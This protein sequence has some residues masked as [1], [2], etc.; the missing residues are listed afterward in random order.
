MK[1]FF[2]DKEIQQLHLWKAFQIS[3][4]TLVTILPFQN[5]S[6]SGLVSESVS[7]FEAENQILSICKFNGTVISEGQSVTAYLSSTADQQNGDSCKQEQRTCTNGALTGSYS[8]AQ[9]S[10]LNAAKAACLFNGKTLSHGETVMAYQNSSVDFGQSCIAEKR[11]C[12]NGVLSGMY[13]FGSCQVAM[14]KSCL[15][16]GKTLNHGASVAA[17]STAAVAYGQKCISENRVCTNGMLSGSNVYGSCVVGTPK[18]CLFNGSTIAH[19]ATVK[20]YLSST[21]KYGSS[22]AVEDRLCNDGL[23]SGSNQYASCQVGV[24]AACLFN[25]QTLASGEKVTAYQSS[26]VAYGL[27]CVYES[28]ECSDGVMK[29]SFTNSSCVVESSQFET[30]CTVD[31]FDKIRKNLSGSFMQICD[32]DLGASLPFQS[33]A[34]DWLNPFTGVFDG[35]GKTIYNLQTEKGLFANI[36]DAKIKNVTIRSAM[37]KR[38]LTPNT[39]QIQNVGI[40]VGLSQKNSR[41]ENVNID[42][43]IE[44][45]NAARVGGVVGNNFGAVDHAIVA[46]IIVNVKQGNGSVTAVGGIVGSNKGSVLSS[47]LLN[48]E[49]NA[50]GNDVGGIAGEMY[51]GDGVLKTY[52]SDSS[53]SGKIIGSQYV[54]GLV[55]A[56]QGQ[57]SNNVKLERSQFSG[58][59][60][61]ISLVGG[62]VGTMS[63]LNLVQIK[64]S[65]S[66]KARQSTAG[67]LV[68]LAYSGFISQSFFRGDSSADAGVAGGLIGGIGGD[69]FQG[70]CATYFA[71]QDSYA[72][73]NVTAK[74]RAGGLSGTVYMCE[75]ASRGSYISR[76][77]FS[78]NINSAAS[79]D[80][81]ALIGF[82]SNSSGVSSNQNQNTVGQSSFLSMNDAY[83]DSTT[84]SG[85]S[86]SLG[87]PLSKVNL[88][89]P[90]AL[91]N[92]NFQ[93]IWKIGADQLP[94]LQMNLNSGEYNTPINFVAGYFETLK[95]STEGYLYMICSGGGLCRSKD[96][97]LTLSS[98]T[99]N[100]G[101][102]PNEITSYDLGPNGK[103]AFGTRS[104]WLYVSNDN[105]ITF[106]QAAKTQ[107]DASRSLSITDVVIDKKGTLYVAT[108]WNPYPIIS[109]D[110][111][112]SFTET[113]PNAYTGQY[114][115]NFLAV[116]DS[117]TIYTGSYRSIPGGVYSVT[118]ENISGMKFNYINSSI[119]V[120]AD[121][122]S[123]FG[124]RLICSTSTGEL[125][126]MDNSTFDFKYASASQGVTQSAIIYRSE[127]KSLDKLSDGTI[128]VI[129][130]SSSNPSAQTV[131]VSNVKGLNSPQV[132]GDISKLTFTAFQAAGLT[133]SGGPTSI[134]VGPNDEIYVYSFW[135]GI[136]KS[137]DRGLTFNV[138]K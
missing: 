72:V 58:S 133:D 114:I 97:G 106:K 4:L 85:I 102:G 81:G 96:G 2:L 44:F 20:G 38:F 11:E 36:S 25:G 54:A 122:F 137:V 79:L 75:P 63:S 50:E 59:V 116:T 120:K 90:A 128:V 73:A 83:W 64:V 31:D 80:N 103:I 8:Y 121:C 13:S 62:A 134:A 61:G 1:I 47:K 118:Q 60:E 131:F 41:I 34:S 125:G 117:G 65:G 89:N 99:A 84:M 26:S 70:G 5:C 126:I 92:W 123:D 104:N 19:G 56:T 132:N 95:V 138:V 40:L 111:G 46:N 93:T 51:E 23:L 6:Q 107:V 32:I 52:I 37:L 124:E 109:L 108:S 14:P 33:I 39:S 98:L 68:G 82:Y 69:G 136:K 57:V 48:A 119:A 100:L 35:N 86:A 22:C 87:Q 10:N 135:T 88:G 76:V 28:R 18:S 45:E 77:Y 78:G 49:I 9:C 113:N 94:D 129:A 66:V 16:D 7:R 43:R 112:N 29:G 27:A 12:N 17:F 24:P 105:G 101:L 110:F 53:A 71:I 67:G 30:I 55:G 15:F 91:F 21:V 74:S 42:G 130:T 115:E 3:T 127:R